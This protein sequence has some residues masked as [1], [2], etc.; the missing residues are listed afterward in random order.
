MLYSDSFQA[1]VL[2]IFGRIY[3]E[4]DFLPHNHNKLALKLNSNVTDF[5]LVGHFFTKFHVET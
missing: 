4:T 1:N 3:T 2:S 5:V